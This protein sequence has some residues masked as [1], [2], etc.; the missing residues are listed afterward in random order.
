MDVGAN[1]YFGEKEW[2]ER[3][4]RCLLATTRFH[5]AHPA[6]AHVGLVETRALGPPAIQRAEES[7]QAFATLLRADSQNTNPLA[8]ATA[9]EAVGAAIF[10]IAHERVLLRR[11]GELPCYAY[12]AT[13]MA[14][15][16]FL[17]V[18]AASR[19]V[20]RKLNDAARAS[21]ARKRSQRS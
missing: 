7:R 20:Q 16:P 17:G 21:G 8:S 11:A 10:E 1:A 9:T 14:L 19:F 6:I 4:W 2:P 5:A 3:V 18:Q 15:T 12:H 13:Y